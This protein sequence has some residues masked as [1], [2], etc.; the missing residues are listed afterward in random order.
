MA[1]PDPGI[2]DESG[3]ALAVADGD[4]PGAGVVESCADEK[5]GS[6]DQPKICC[7]CADV[8][9]APGLPCAVSYEGFTPLC[10]P[11]PRCCCGTRVR[12]TWAKS[13]VYETYSLSKGTGNFQSSKT[14]WEEKFVFEAQVVTLKDG[15][16]RIDFTAISY[17]AEYHQVSNNHYND[18]DHFS[19]D[20]LVDDNLAH[21]FPAYGLLVNPQRCCRPE[22]VWMVCRGAAPLGTVLFHD[23]HNDT[24]LC[25]LMQKFGC[26]GQTQHHG[27]GGDVRGETVWTASASCKA[28]SVKVDSQLHVEDQYSKDDQ[29]FVGTSA[30]GLEVLEDGC[31]PPPDGGFHPSGPAVPVDP[32]TGSPYNPAPPTVPVDINPGQGQACERCG[33]AV[34]GD[35]CLW[36]G[37]CAGCGG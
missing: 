7:L 3:A 6:C 24:T 33:E 14:T 17:H 25:G 27:N 21:G 1:D 20:D 10:N 30:M 32:D 19:Y 9:A 36:C 15:T 18:K 23:E 4:L 22:P 26:S 29:S 31:C 16:C 28:F 8:E 34:R 37:W 12:I 35:R 13:S 2:T 11:K 5:C